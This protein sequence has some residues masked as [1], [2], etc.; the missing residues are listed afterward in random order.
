MT[1]NDRYPPRNPSACFVCGAIVEHADKVLDEYNN[2]MW[3]FSGIRVVAICPLIVIHTAC[4]GAYGQEFGSIRDAL[5]AAR[6]AQGPP[7]AAGGGT[8]ADRT[9]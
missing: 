1:M 5:D 3:E 2:G 8:N 6:E 9:R 4:E 7:E